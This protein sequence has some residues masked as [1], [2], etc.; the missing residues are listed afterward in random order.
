M[1]WV[2]EKKAAQ[3]AVD[4]QSLF[5]DEGKHQDL[6]ADKAFGPKYLGKIRVESMD[7]SASYASNFPYFR[8]ADRAKEQVIA[9]FEGKYGRIADSTTR[10]R[11]LSAVETI[12]TVFFVCARDA[13]G[14]RVT[15]FV[16]PNLLQE[17]AAKPES[18]ES[19]K[20]EFK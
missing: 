3:A 4:Q 5:L 7:L 14:K 10:S 16:D 20:P 8:S 2:M 15:V 9:F 11:L 19:W 17:V 1:A 6:G 18:S 13:E 12:G